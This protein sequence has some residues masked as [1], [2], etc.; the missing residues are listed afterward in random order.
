MDETRRSRDF[1]K[2]PIW[3]PGR[4]R[5]LVEIRYPDDSRAAEAAPRER[6]A[7]RLWSGEQD[8]IKNGT[9]NVRAPKTVT[10]GVALD[11]YRAHAKVHVSSY[12]SYTRA[13]A[14]GVGSWHTE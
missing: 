13:S 5:W 4:S 10:F 7:L 8:K 12:K 3:D 9:W 14:K 6:D 1:S 11:L 2:G